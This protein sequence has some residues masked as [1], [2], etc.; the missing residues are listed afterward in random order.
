VHFFGALGMS[1][2]CMWVLRPLT[3]WQVRAPDLVD[4]SYSG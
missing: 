3:R 1:V 2:V 4:S